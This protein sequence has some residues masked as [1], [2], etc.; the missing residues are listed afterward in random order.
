[1]TTAEIEQKAKDNGF[2]FFTSH[3]NDPLVAAV[4]CT[5]MNVIERDNLI[6]Q[7][8]EKGEYLAAA[9]KGLVEKHEVVG[10]A[11]GR[12]LLQG[13]EIVKDKKSKVRSEEIGDL[14]TQECFKLGLH[15]NIVCLPGMGGV[16]RIAPPLTVSYEE[17]DE[18][19]SIL[20]KA[21]T[22]VERKLYK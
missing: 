13:I 7:S 1:V 17:L 21:I 16:F 12:G 11:R 6:V 4:G 9:L 3:V 14:I 22:E 2:V 18:G 8:K 10:N 5:V 15:M 20:D 19:I